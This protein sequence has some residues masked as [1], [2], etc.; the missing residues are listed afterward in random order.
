MATDP[1]ATEAAERAIVD[2]D[3]ESADK[4]EDISKPSPSPV[5]QSPQIKRHSWEYVDEI[6]ALLKT[7][8]PLLALSME[9]MADQIINKLKPTMDEDI[10]R[11]IIAL[12]NDGIQV[13]YI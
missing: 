12:L 2:T 6:M 8:F 4:K 7:A 13:T 3:M 11:L 9:T 1:A 10:Y 5:P